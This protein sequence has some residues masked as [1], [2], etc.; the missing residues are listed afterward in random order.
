MKLKNFLLSAYVVAC[1]L[2]AVCEGIFYWQ[3]ADPPERFLAIAFMLSVLLLAGWVDLDSKEQGKKIYRPHE[4]GFLVFVYWIPYLPYY[5]WR[6][7]GVLGVFKL[8]GLVSL[9]FLGPLVQSLIY[10]TR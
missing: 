7:R 2:A 5:F 10:L 8:A 6:T 1:A 9:L 3:G 4:F